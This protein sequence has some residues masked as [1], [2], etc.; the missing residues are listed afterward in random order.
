M[1]PTAYPVQAGTHALCCKLTA[2][3]PLSASQ[4]S[5]AL[6]M[7][8]VLGTAVYIV[9]SNN[10]F[11]IYLCDVFQHPALASPYRSDSRETTLKLHTVAEQHE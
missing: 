3:P 10:L 1:R 6:L 5:T 4:D 2:V 11:A 7:H 8:A 9:I